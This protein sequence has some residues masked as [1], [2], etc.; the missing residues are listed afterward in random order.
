MKIFK[1]LIAASFLATVAFGSANALSVDDLLSSPMINLV[2][3]DGV[4]N[5]YGSVDTESDS[6]AAEHAA[7]Q[8]EGVESVRNNL[9][10]SVR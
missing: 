8:I 2:V 6:I 9:F 7:A 5:L 10:F 1:T 3:K 4:A